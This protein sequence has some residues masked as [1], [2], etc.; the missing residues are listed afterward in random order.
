MN[1]SKNPKGSYND[2]QTIL[3]FVLLLLF[4]LRFSVFLSASVSVHDRKRKAQNRNHLLSP[5]HID[6]K[7]PGLELIL[8]SNDFDAAPL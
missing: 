8:D 5:Y 3:I 6:S 7:N 2:R 4:Q 1:F